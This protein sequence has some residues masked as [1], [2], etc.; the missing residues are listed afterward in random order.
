MIDVAFQ[1]PECK[2]CDG[3]TTG[4]E[5]PSISSLVRSMLPHAADSHLAEF[6]GSWPQ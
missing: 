3:D 4:N 6:L 1:M 5:G 2:V